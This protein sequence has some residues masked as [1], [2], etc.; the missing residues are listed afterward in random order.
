M[1]KITI[2]IDFGTSNTVISFYKKSP[3][4]FKDSIKD[5]IPTKIY[6]GDKIYC[7]NNIPID[8][9][10][11]DKNILSNFKIKIGSNFDFTYKDKILKEADILK[12][13]FNHLKKL[14]D[15]NFPET[16]F[17]AVLTVPSNFNDNQRTTLI[18]V[19]K[20]IGFNIL[21]II[22]EPTAAAFAYG[23]NQSIED[24]SILVFDLQKIIFAKPA[25]CNPTTSVA[26]LNKLI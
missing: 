26:F 13:F 6:F 7:G 10:E 23:L 2:G 16:E 8:V 5:S 4:I 24:E 19:S 20:S 17:S 3:I 9:N 1:K 21:R 11:K 12:I 15:K 14:L 25:P 18:N 22:N